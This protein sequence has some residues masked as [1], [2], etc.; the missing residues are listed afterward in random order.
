[1]NAVVVDARV[2]A[3][4]CFFFFSF[5][6]GFCL[7]KTPARHLCLTFCAV[8]SNYSINSMHSTNTNT[9]LCLHFGW[10]SFSLTR[11]LTRLFHSLFS[12]FVYFSCQFHLHMLSVPIISSMFVKLSFILRILFCVFVSSSLLH[13]CVCACSLFNVHPPN[14]FPFG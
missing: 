14:D 10:I 2:C 3:F 13:L 1:M 5:F 11:S 12:Y 9:F 8:I 6:F 4:V 7:S